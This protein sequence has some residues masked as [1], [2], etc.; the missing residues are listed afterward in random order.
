[1]YTVPAHPALLRGAI[2]VAG[3]VL[4]QA[5]MGVGSIGVVKRVEDSEGP[6]GRQLVHRA[7]RPAV[8]RGA[9]Q[10]AGAV[11]DQTSRGVVSIG[12]DKGVEDGERLS[13]STIVR[14]VAPEH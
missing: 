6:A 4:D 11:L 3:A 5:S 14:S 12:A 13:G 10:V 7:V 8:R 9:V 1:H 2:Q